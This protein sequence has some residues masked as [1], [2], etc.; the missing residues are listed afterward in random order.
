MINIEML[1]IALGIA[2]SPI[3]VIAVIVMLFSARAKSNSIAFAATWFLAIALVGA[4]FIMLASGQEMI[5]SDEGEGGLEWVKIVLGILLLL[6]AAN[7]FKS[8]PKKG[9][10]PEMPTWLVKIEEFTPVKSGG[11]A[12]LLSVINPKNLPLII[13]GALFIAGSGQ[14]DNTTWIN[15]GVFAIIASF[16]VIAPVVYYFI[17][18]KKAEKTLTTWKEWLSQNNAMVMFWLLLIV[19]VILLVEGFNVM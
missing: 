15:L 8:R 2:I 17:A 5:V 16:T 4:G 18:G 9:E 6:M 14:I 12:I 13:A 7:N 1:P 19:G 3:P 10:K 11:L